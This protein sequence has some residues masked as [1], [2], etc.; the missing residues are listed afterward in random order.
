MNIR[1]AQNILNPKFVTR[2][3]HLGDNLN[4]L[5]RIAAHSIEIIRG[6]YFLHLKNLFI[7]VYQPMNNIFRSTSSHLFSHWFRRRGIR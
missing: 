3:I 5:N 6:L 7:Y 4:R 1:I 2:G